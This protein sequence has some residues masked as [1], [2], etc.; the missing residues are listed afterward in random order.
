MDEVKR[1]EIAGR[2]VMGRIATWAVIAV[3]LILIGAALKAT[4]LITVP[5]TYAVFITIV[6]APLDG[7]VSRHMPERLSWLGHVAA[8]LTLAVILAVFVAGLAI[9]ARQLMD[10]GSSLSVEVDSIVSGAAEAGSEGENASAGGEAAAPPASLAS[11]T[12]FADEALDRAREYVTSLAATIVNKSLVLISSVVLIFFLV[13][14]MLSERKAWLEKLRRIL[15]ETS[16]DTIRDATTRIGEQVRNFVI[17]RAILGVATGLLYVFWLWLFGIDLLF[18]WFTVTFLLNF[19]PNI[20]SLIS[21]I[22]ASGYAVLTKDW[23]TAI[24]VALGLIAIEQVMGNFIDPKVQGRAVGLSTVVTLVA[25]FFWGFLWGVAGA[26]LAVPI[27]IVALNVFAR[28][29]RLMP[30]ALLV[31]DETEAD[32]VRENVRAGDDALRS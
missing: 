12:R 22:A 8:I 27:T 19:V 5:L 4:A 18:V 3:A 6:L 25:L 15:P 13:L 30:L 28:I 16:C 20:G 2:T 7:F 26:V 24:W 10:E 29:D 31:S 14:L 1:D 32:E 11:V 9:S 17:A 23:G 21:G